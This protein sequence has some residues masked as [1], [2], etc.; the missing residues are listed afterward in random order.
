MMLTLD[1]LKN[2]VGVYSDEVYGPDRT[3]A[4]PLEKLH[5]EIQECMQGGEIEE[6]ADCLL[7]LLD[8]FRKRYPHQ[9]TSFLLISAEHK[10]QV[11]R[12]KAARKI[13]Q[14]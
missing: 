8:S 10:L 6:Y 9:S 14:A 3:Y 5:E 1:E 13:K 7:C 11:L 4:A 2:I 12:T